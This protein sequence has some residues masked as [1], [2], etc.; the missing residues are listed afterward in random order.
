MR[1]YWMEAA[2]GAGAGARRRRRSVRAHGASSR[3]AARRGRPVARPC[4]QWDAER[5]DATG[6]AWRQ[7]DDAAAA[8]RVER[9]SELH[10]LPSSLTGKQDEKESK[11]RVGEETQEQ[12]HEQGC[13]QIKEES[14]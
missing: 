9:A 13:S 2:E 14:A 4:C 10:V 11:A 8:S 3:A 5:L 12:E 6:L 7:P 1:L